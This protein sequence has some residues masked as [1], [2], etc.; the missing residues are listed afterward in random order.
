MYVSGS[1]S[2]SSSSHFSSISAISVSGRGTKAIRIGAKA[3]AVLRCL[4][5]QAW[6]PRDESHPAG[7]RLAR[8]A[9]WVAAVLTV[10]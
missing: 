4:L 10:V 3:F 8:D 7:D 6:A 1:I 2:L 5:T 9:W